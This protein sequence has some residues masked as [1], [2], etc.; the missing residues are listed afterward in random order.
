MD[1]MELQDKPRRLEAPQPKDLAL[2][3]WNAKA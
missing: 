2:E 3:N 1:C